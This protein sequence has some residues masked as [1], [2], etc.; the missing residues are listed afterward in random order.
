M[1]RWQVCPLST[2]QLARSLFNQ[3]SK[4]V[5]NEYELDKLVATCKQLLQ[6]DKDLEGVVLFLREQTG[7]K[8]V[9]IVVLKRLLNISMGEAQLVV[10]TSEAWSDVRER[11]ERFEQIFVTALEQLAKKQET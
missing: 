2:R 3:E 7:K 9:S 4:R 8:L 11:D 6:D 5:M 1:P 10:H